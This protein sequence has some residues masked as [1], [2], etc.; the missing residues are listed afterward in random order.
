MNLRCGSCRVVYDSEIAECPNCG[1]PNS[2]FELPVKTCIEI[3]IELAV[4]RAMEEQAKIKGMSISE[5]WQD[6]AEEWIT[7]QNY[8]SRRR[9][10]SRK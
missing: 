10:V 4:V 7:Y 9:H 2:K 1:F 8:G 6:A 3:E 5:A